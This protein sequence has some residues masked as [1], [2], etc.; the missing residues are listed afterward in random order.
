[1]TAEIAI[2]NRTAVALAADS[3]VTLGVRG[4]QKIYNSV[5]KLFQLSPT[6]PVGIMVFGGAEYMGIPIETVIKKFRTSKYCQPKKKLRDY[7]DAFFD[8][9]E[10]EIVVPQDLVDKNVREILAECFSSISSKSLDRYMRA[11]TTAKNPQ[12]LDIQKFI[13]TEAENITKALISSF[14]KR[15][16]NARIR[17]TDN[18]DWY[19][20]A[21]EA[22]LK[23]TIRFPISDELRA[24]L[25]ELGGLTLHKDVYSTGAMGLVFAGFGSEEMFPKLQAFHSDGLVHGH[26]KR[27]DF[28]YVDINRTGDDSGARIEAFAQKEMVHRFLEGIDPDYESYL[29]SAMREALNSFGND[30]IQTFVKSSKSKKAEMVAKMSTSADKYLAEFATKSEQRKAM[31]FRQKILDMVNFMPKSDLANMA[32]SLI[33]LTSTK[34]RVSA[35]SETVGGPIDVAVISKYDGFV[36]IKRKHYFDKE[37]NPRYFVS[38]LRQLGVKGGEK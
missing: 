37:L 17:T 13:E 21:A 30:I 24:L 33:N 23:E 1:M 8:F 19:K 38:Q 36:W 7:S 2:L 5:D 34:R 16:D 28:R 20:Q 10:N 3:A 27:L 26:V 22:A 35:E 14:K 31:N 4:Q 9:L 29:R 12:K 15:S 18:G 6:E 32:E 11:A 25:M